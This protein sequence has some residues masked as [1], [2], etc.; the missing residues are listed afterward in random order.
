MKNYIVLL[1]LLIALGCIRDEAVLPS[2]EGV[3][4]EYEGMDGPEF[5][6]ELCS[7]Y[8]TCGGTVQ[9]PVSLKNYKLDQSLETLN[10]STVT[11][12]TKVE[13]NGHTLVFSVESGSTFEVNGQTFNLIQFHTHTPSEHSLTGFNNLPM[14]LHFVH[15]NPINGNLAVVGVLVMYGKSNRLFTEIQ[16]NLPKSKGDSL[17]LDYQFDPGS[18]LPSLNSYFTYNGSLTTPPCSEIV[19]W[20]VMESPIEASISQI[21]KFREIEMENNRPLQNL[22]KRTV[23]Y[24]KD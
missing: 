16:N 15:Q 8:T 2:C 3:H 4:W 10:I 7:D 13:N 21:E 5:W 11:T 19:T 23:Y 9:S 22:G 12:K 6:A 1:I 24:F 20:F 17:V 18:L 14:E